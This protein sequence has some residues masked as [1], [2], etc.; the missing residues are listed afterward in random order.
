MRVRLGQN[1]LG[2]VLGSGGLRGA[3]HLGILQCLEC[4]DIVPYCLSGSSAGAV[5]AGLYAA[6]F[7]VA[8]MV[9]LAM[10]L[11]LQQIY[12]PD[13]SW[14]ALGALGMGVW[15]HWLRLPLSR[16]E[17]LPLGLLRG[18]AWQRYLERLLGQTGFADLPRQVA[19]LAVDIETGADVAFSPSRLSSPEVTIT[20]AT[21]AQAI[22]ASSAIPGIFAP[23]QVAGRTLV[24]GAVKASVPVDLVRDLGADIVVAVDLGYAGQRDRPVQD[25]V[26]VITQSLSIMGG[27]LT[28]QQLA[29]KSEFVIRPKIYD[30]SWLD[31]ARI[32]EMIARGERAMEEAIPSLLRLL[33]R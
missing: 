21:V 4:H 9:E 13:I 32:P 16:K 30:V 3:A 5:V 27:E 1:K 33:A 25:M 7:T 24:D 31:F 8:E 15:R 23:A 22:R 18:Q 19:I 6:G 10:S 12:D 26:E 17:L 20:T 11:S 28:R 2:L 14:R 29:G